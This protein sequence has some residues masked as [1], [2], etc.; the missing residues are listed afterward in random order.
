MA[1]GNFSVP[2]KEEL[3][4]GIPGKVQIYTPK[5]GTLRAGGRF[6]NA[7]LTNLFWI[8]A[9]DVNGDGID[10]II[11]NT[12]EGVQLLTQKERRLYLVNRREGLVIRRL[13]DQLFAQRMD[14]LDNGEGP[15]HSVYW[16]GEDW[17]TGEVVNSSESLNLFAVVH[18]DT[19]APV[20]IGPDH[21]LIRGEQ[22]V[23]EETFG[24]SNTPNI[25]EIDL[26]IFARALPHPQGSL[27]LKN[28]PVAA[29]ILKRGNKYSNGGKVV[30]F[31]DS[32]PSNISPRFRGYLADLTLCDLDGDGTGEI[33]L[34]QVDAGFFGGG[35]YI[36]QYK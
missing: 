31:S 15:I 4:I 1:A 19:D 10:E 23:S 34:S 32:N 30:L 22:A 3:I 6:E 27:L 2:G 17:E 5:K 28:I 8:D 20:F 14:D 26:P 33:L 13:G 29:A 9:W 12:D 24:Q 18:F 36:L 7:D 21:K 16:N 11:V 25:L 35:A